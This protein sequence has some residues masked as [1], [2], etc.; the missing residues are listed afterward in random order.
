VYTTMSGSPTQGLVLGISPILE[1]LRVLFYW[2]YH[3]I[4]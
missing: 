2:V 1:K 4:F 3:Q